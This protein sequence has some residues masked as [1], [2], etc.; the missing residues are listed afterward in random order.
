M[1]ISAEQGGFASPGILSLPVL[2]QYRSAR[3]GRGDL[4]LGLTLTSLLEEE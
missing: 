1:I 3:P 4:P 2:P